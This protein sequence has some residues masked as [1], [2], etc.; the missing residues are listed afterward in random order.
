MILIGYLHTAIQGGCVNYFVEIRP[1][2]LLY[3]SKNDVK[4]HI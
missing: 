3:H 2:L 1:V 4:L